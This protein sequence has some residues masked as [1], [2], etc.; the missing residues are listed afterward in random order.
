MRSCVYAV[1]IF[2]D[3]SEEVGEGG[4]GDAEGHAA[5]VVSAD[6]HFTS[7]KMTR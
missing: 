7:S 3:E 2:T 4:D 5:Y 6:V 1:S